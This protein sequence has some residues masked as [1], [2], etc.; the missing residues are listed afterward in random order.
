[1]KRTFVYLLTSF[2]L[3][4]GLFSCASAP[5]KK[6]DSVYVMVYNCENS[7][8]MDA[9]IFV[10]G[11]K[12]GNTDIYGRFIFPT[13]FDKKKMHKVRVEKDGYE[14]SEIE[15][16]LTDGQVIYFKIGTANYYAVQAEKLLDEGNTANALD[17]IKNALKIE[18]REDY[19]YLQKVILKRLENEKV[20]EAE[21][22]D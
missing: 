2:F 11:K 19:Q 10:D 3:I 14:K 9:R 20:K 8:V 18:N 21:T 6:M 7:E 5:E 12:E 22:K 4:L 17:M 15:T 16:L 13:P 1:M